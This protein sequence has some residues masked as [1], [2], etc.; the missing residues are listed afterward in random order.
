MKARED[1]APPGPAGE[2]QPKAAPAEAPK[3]LAE[4]PKLSTA[5]D[6]LKEWRKKRKQKWRANRAVKKKESP[7]ADT[8]CRTLAR[9]LRRPKQSRRK[10]KA[11]PRIRRQRKEKASGRAAR[12]AAR[13]AQTGKAARAKAKTTKAKPLGRPKGPLLASPKARAD[14][15]PEKAKERDGR[16]NPAGSR[17]KA[18]I[19]TIVG[20][21]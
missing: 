5:I 21:P 13:K 16:L 12:K 6:K 7:G 19:G 11:R 18:G 20:R 3:S 10:A 4:A 14:A 8:T 9:G 2:A 17:I 15:G 1:P